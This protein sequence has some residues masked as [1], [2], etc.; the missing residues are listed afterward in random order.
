MGNKIEPT[1]RLATLAAQ[2]AYV[3]QKRR[4]HFDFSL[5]AG[6][7]FVRGIRDLGYKSSGTA[8]DELLDN[9]VEAGASKIEVVFG[10]EKSDA[11]PSAIAVM[12]DGHG[13]DAEMVRLSVIWG[14]THR[15]NSRSG[16]GRYGYGLP[17]ATV[18]I[19]RRYTVYSKTDK[20]WNAVTIDLDD[21]VAGKHSVDGRVIVPAS[22]TQ[23]PPA[24]VDKAYVDR[25][26]KST[27]HGTIIV[28][29][30]LDR[31]EYKTAKRLQDELLENI[32]V[33]YRNTLR[34]I[35]MFVNGVAVEPVDPLFLMSEARFVELDDDRAEPLPSTVIEVKPKDGRPGG[36]IRVRYA[37]LPPTFQRRD[38]DSKSSSK[39]NMNERFPIMRDH[40]G[41]VLL[42]NGRQI[43]VV[44]RNPFFSFTIYDRNIKV[45]IDFDASLDEEFGVTTSKQQITISDR[46]WEILKE[47]RVIAAVEGLRRR[48][49]RERAEDRAAEKED[50]KRASEQAMESAERVIK[51]SK[52]LRVVEKEIAAVK[53]LDREIRKRAENA[54][55]SPADVERA[56]KAEL[57]S[58]P[59]KVKLE[60]QP[61]GSFFRVE[62]VGSQLALYLNTAHRFF[63]DLYSA[64]SATNEVRAALEV[65]LFCIGGAELDASADYELFY[66]QERR[67]WSSRLDIALAK[68]DEV[69]E[70]HPEDQ[71][72]EPV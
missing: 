38:K 8:I 71:E 34:A 16:F 5:V 47:S 58:Q 66:R 53:A 26:G 1:T 55:L 48:N 6:A 35:P 70:T 49:A 61:D 32:G 69:Q 50:A 51:R 20:K 52:S 65:L 25:F 31:I 54:N 10:Y 13:M 3:E 15:E 67:E 68:L 63:T 57:A 60:A 17:S 42:R 36:L 46:I 59:Y 7:A 9:G 23:V 30:K 39:S 12:D 4:E 29:E 11:K 43:D 64:P 19:G 37:Y 41:F 22:V 14:G 62:Q 72:P 28:I 44:T 18:S 21:I 33:T 40:N 27:T 24:W 56:V 2:R 45:E